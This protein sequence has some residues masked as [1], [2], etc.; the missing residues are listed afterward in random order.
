ME[1]YLSNLESG[2]K[3]IQLIGSLD[4][5]GTNEVN[6]KFTV[7]ASAKKAAV[8]VDLSQVDYLASIGLRLLITS[9]R[10]LQQRGGKMVLLNPSPGVARVLSL[11]GFETIIPV[12][13]DLDAACADGLAA[14]AE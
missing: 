6:L 1:A 3:L 5:Q 2:V 11:S 10:A 9:A 12:F 7:Y 14:I 13:T 8:V 4:M